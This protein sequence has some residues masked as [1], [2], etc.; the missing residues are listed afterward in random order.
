MAEQFDQTWMAQNLKKKQLNHLTDEKRNGPDTKF[1]LPNSPEYL[2]RN[3]DVQN[4][5]WKLE[6]DSQFG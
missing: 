1:D 3:T 6:T 5:F 4:A 2:L